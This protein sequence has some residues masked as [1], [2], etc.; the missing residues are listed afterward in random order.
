MNNDIRS[1][2]KGDKVIWII[3][4]LLTTISVV[5]VFSASSQ[6]VVGSGKV[7]SIMLKHI[8]LI[9]MGFVILLIVYAMKLKWVKLLSF[10]IV[11]MILPI[12]VYLLLGGES[13]QGAARTFFGFQPSEFA[14]FGLIVFAAS[15]M[16]KLQETN[17]D[18]TIF[19]WFCLIIYG[20][21]GL[22]LPMNL[23]QAIIISVP[24]LIIMIIGK[25]PWRKLMAFVGIPL[26]LLLFVGILATGLK[27]SSDTKV[28]GVL[29]KFRFDTWVGRFR[30]HVD[31]VEGWQQAETNAEKWELIRKYDQVIY[32][33][34]AIYDSD[35]GVSPGRSQW[36]NR[37]QEVS[38][39][40]IYAMIVE[41]YGILLGGL[42]VIALYM[43]LLWRGR[44]LVRRS[45]NTTN[46]L[47]IVGSITLIVFQAFVH[48]GVCVGVIP[49]TGQTLPL[50]SKGGTS[51]AV[52]GAMFGLILGMSK[53]LDDQDAKDI[54]SQS[55]EL[56]KSPDA[57]IE[58]SDKEQVESIDEATEKSEEATFLSDDIS[59]TT[60]PVEEDDF[61]PIEEQAFEEIVFIE[62]KSEE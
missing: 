36:R 57:S 14:K 30:N 56:I 34:S 52:M 31:V 9:G 44:E 5:A 23:S 27:V 38:K 41:E 46:Q 35:F 49:V 39:D 59:V 1:R 55:S 8:M 3:Y 47:I 43:W 4:F 45:Q 29:N 54:L 48:I 61:I 19:R 13:H 33:K 26:L 18:T 10:F 11:I 25:T 7:L 37:I 12:L 40:F 6:L 21:V 22:I 17:F 20:V 15:A 50:I 24:V 53:K 58:D 60:Q 62:K 42:G 51:M 16:S 32:S 28:G 2:L